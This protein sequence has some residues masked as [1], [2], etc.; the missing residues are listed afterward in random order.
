MAY[1][2]VNQA[3]TWKHEISGGYMWSPKRNQ[4][5]ARNQFYENMR[6]AQ[7]GD[8]VFAYYKQHIQQ[9]GVVQCPAVSQSKPTDFGTVGDYWGD[10]GWFVPVEWHSLS[11]PFRPKTLIEELRP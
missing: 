5:G 7:A 8:L 10:D 9:L 4:I 2:W 6:Q 1:W 3:Q 11:A